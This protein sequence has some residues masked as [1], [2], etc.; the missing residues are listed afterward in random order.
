MA[1]SL[2]VES[3]VAIVSLAGTVLASSLLGSAHCAGMCGGVALV[4]IGADGKSRLARQLGYHAGRLVSYALVGAA[5]G[6]IGIAIDDA[7]TL[8]GF[9][10]VA[11]IAAGITIALF[12]FVA[13]LRAFGARVPKAGVPAPLVAVAQRVHVRAMKLPPAWRGVPLGLATPLLPCGW[14]YAFAAIAAGSASMAMGA[15]VMA[16]FWLG[17]VPALVVA[18]NGAR[19][20]FAKLG[21][22]AP[23]IAGLAMMAVGLHA[24]MWRSSVADDAIQGLAMVRVVREGSAPAACVDLAVEASELANELPPCCRV[25]AE[26]APTSGTKAS[27]LSSGGV[28]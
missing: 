20:A 14:L 7:G 10:R 24:A 4:A 26:A 27:E 28:P 5:C 16:A 6:V 11:A 2:A 13:I 9:Q 15:L 22:L 25:H 12:G 17:T 19:L 1:E 3:A 8:V 23:V 18:S 21:R